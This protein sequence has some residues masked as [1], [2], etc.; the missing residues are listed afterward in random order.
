MLLIRIS[1]YFSPEYIRHDAV[2]VK[3]IIHVID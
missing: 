2:S 1:L 3:S